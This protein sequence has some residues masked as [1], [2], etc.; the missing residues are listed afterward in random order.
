MTHELWRRKVISKALALG[1]AV[2]ALAGCATVDPIPP[3]I[4]RQK[5]SA[6]LGVGATSVWVPSRGELVEATLMLIPHRTETGTRLADALS[7]AKDSEVRI[8]IAGPSSTLT[9]L[10]ALE[11]L[12]RVQGPLPGLHFLFIGER[13]DEAD[14]REAVEKKGGRFLFA[15]GD[16]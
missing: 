15:E 6:L 2:S 13:R 9:R 16:D 5:A 7:R 14:V 4:A 1:L 10:I 8:G 11:G 3:V 12:A